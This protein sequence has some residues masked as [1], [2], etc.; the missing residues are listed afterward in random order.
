[1]LIVVLV[2][3][4]LFVLFLRTNPMGREFFDRARTLIAVNLLTLGK[5]VLPHW[6]RRNP[7]VLTSSLTYLLPIGRKNLSLHWG[8]GNP[9]V[10]AL[11]LTLPSS[12]RST[13]TSLS[14][15]TPKQVVGTPSTLSPLSMSLAVSA[16]HH[17]KNCQI[18]FTPPQQMA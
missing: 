2:V 18:R 15:V 1:M 3:T 16:T 13:S 12:I 4:V 9:A 14:N 6:G 8:G 10:L 7:A 17:Q 11:S 5:S